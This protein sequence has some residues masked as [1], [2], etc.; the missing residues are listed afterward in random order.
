MEGF[1]FG[2]GELYFHMVICMIRVS[3]QGVLASLVV[4]AKLCRTRME[5]V[6]NVVVS[7]M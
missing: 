6:L 7:A 1:L 4:F 5:S 3:I 2:P